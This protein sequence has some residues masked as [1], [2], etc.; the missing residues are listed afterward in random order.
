MQISPESGMSNWNNSKFP[1]SDLNHG[2][3]LNRASSQRFYSITLRSAMLGGLG[4]STSEAWNILLN[5]FKKYHDEKDSVI[6]WLFFSLCLWIYIN[7][8]ITSWQGF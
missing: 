8:Q 5:G 4:T 6:Y 7:Q 2:N 3:E 1:K